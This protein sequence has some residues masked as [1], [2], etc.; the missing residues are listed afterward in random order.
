M[1]IFTFL[2]HVTTAPE[3]SRFRV[4]LHEYVQKNGGNL[5]DKYTEAQDHSKRTIFKCTLTY[6]VNGR[7]TTRD[8]G[9]YYPRKDEAKEMAAKSVYL[10]VSS[11]GSGGAGPVA[12]STRGAVQVVQSGATSSD[13][14]WVSKLKE[15]YDKQG[16]PGM[17][18]DFKVQETAVGG[19][20]ARIFVP[21][22]GREV[23]GAAAKSKKEA[24]QNAAKK[25][26]NSIK[27]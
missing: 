4:L 5:I 6:S 22:L 11:G 8:S 15:H 1:T 21:E 25:A 26:L 10:V 16:K 7:S 12:T 27:K 20:I 23:E 3:G 13:V 24:K 9:S 17:G 18:Q 14:S 2:G 19:F